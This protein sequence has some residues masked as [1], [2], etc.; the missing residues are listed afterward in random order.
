[1]LQVCQ[2]AEATFSVPEIAWITLKEEQD[3]ENALLM[4]SL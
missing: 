3:G 1:M 2:H 4:V